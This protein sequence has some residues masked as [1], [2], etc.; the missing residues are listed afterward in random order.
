MKRLVTIMSL[1]AIFS[2]AFHYSESAFYAHAERGLSA[3]DNQTHDGDAIGI[4]AVADHFHPNGLVCSVRDQ[5]LTSGFVARA[6][7]S[8]RA[9]QS[10]NSG[11]DRP[12]RICVA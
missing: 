3:A 12:P 8:R 10:R 7:T 6:E 2:V 11:L 9:P 4:G 5:C 1:V